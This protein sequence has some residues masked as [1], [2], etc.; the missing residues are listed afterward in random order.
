[1]NYRYQFSLLNVLIFIIFFTAFSVFSYWQ[2]LRVDEKQDILNKMEEANN[3]SILNID[4]IKENELLN[5]EFYKAQ[6]QGQLLT[7]ECFFLENIVL[8][9]Q[10]GMY[11]YCPYKLVDSNKRLLVNLGWIKRGL[12]RNEIPLISFGV[13]SSQINGVIKKPR[14]K[15]V[16]TSK[17]GKPNTELDNLWV[18]FDF[19][20][21]TELTTDHYLPIVLQLE[22]QVA[23]ELTQQWPEYDAKIGMHWGYVLHWG[24]FALA[25]LILFIKFNFKKVRKDD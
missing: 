9:G 14:S 1:M 7:D 3:G 5:F 23:K 24:A 11:V 6:A 19:D 10:H 13:S 22:T 4:S 17:E 8:S 20:Y 21:L 25:S 2:V 15:P 12:K 18:Y 16:V